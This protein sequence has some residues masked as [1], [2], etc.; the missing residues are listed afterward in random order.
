M[1]VKS[2]KM[3]KLIEIYKDLTEQYTPGNRLDYAEVAKLFAANQDVDLEKE[4]DVD[5]PMKEEDDSNQD[6][7][8]MIR[9]FSEIVF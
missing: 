3:K 4:L 2:P 1:N 5:T 7:V 8:K 9:Y 6:N